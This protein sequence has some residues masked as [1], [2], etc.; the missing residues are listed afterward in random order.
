MLVCVFVLECVLVCVLVVCNGHILETN[1]TRAT[2]FGMPIHS[3][4]A[5]RGEG[6]FKVRLCSRA[7]PD[8]LRDV[9]DFV[10]LLG[11]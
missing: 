1:I 7:I 8:N 2:K 10:L 9:C 3:K 5:N 11:C 6:I 4:G